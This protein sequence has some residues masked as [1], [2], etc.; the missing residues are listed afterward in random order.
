MIDV[1]TYELLGTV[2]MYAVYG[3]GGCCDESGGRSLRLGQ[4][5][6]SINHIEVIIILRE[7]MGRRSRIEEVEMDIWGVLSVG[8]GN[9]ICML[10]E[11]N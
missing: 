5:I 1:G 9:S 2:N 4:K 3:G 10:L 7:L 8:S 11:L 6:M